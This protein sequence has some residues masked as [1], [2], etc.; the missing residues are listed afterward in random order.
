MY[1]D[2]KNISFLN[3]SSIFFWLI[4]CVFRSDSGVTI[5]QSN[6]AAGFWPILALNRQIKAISQPLCYFYSLDVFLSIV[7]IILPIKDVVL[8]VLFDLNF[9]DYIISFKYYWFLADFE[10]PK[11]LIDAY[12]GHMCWFSSFYVFLSILIVTL[13]SEIIRYT[14][15]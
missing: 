11:N 14:I 10:P 5:F 6:I 2:S 1:K 13:L 3:H 7:L 15:V 4:I 8:H 9:R 12:N